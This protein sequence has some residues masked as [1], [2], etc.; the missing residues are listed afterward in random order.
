MILVGA[1]AEGQTSTA[2]GTGS[3]DAPGSASDTPARRDGPQLQLGA[4]YEHLSNGYSPWRNAVLDVQAVG[5]RGGVRAAVEESSRFSTVDHNVIIG[6]ERRLASQWIVSGEAELSPSHHVSPLWGALGQVG[7]LAGNG[8]SLQA[9]LRH[10]RYTSSSVDLATFTIERYVSRYRAAY[11]LYLTRLHGGEK[12]TSH[13]VQGDLY[14]GPLSSSVGVSLAAG[15]EVE[16]VGSFGLL[17]TD[18]RAVAVTGRQWFSPKWFL[19]YEALVHE[20][21]TLYSRRRLGVAVGHRF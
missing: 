5:P 7:I 9:N 3:L 17:R 19:R 18:V 1:S 21:G 11:S 10:R 6:V 13:R 14:F 16:S 4:G 12:S 20:Q 2:P 15:Q 8:W